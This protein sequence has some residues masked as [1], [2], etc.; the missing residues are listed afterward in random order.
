[1][2]RKI[3]NYLLI[4][5]I[6]FLIIIGI[7]LKPIKIKGNSMSPRLKDGDWVLINKIAYT[8]SKPQRQDIIVFSA[9]GDNEKYMVKRII[10]L[11]G[12]SIQITSGSIYI[13]NDLLNEYYIESFGKDNFHKRIIPENYY[14]VLGDNRKIS[15]DSRY[16]EVGFINKKHIIGKIIFKW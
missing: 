8:L 2:I 13:D 7:S 16:K 11:E 4:S 14:F 9:Q 6:L 10:G 15:I 5:L 1:M 3:L 12:E